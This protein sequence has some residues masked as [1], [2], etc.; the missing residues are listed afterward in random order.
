MTQKFDRMLKDKSYKYAPVVIEAGRIVN[1][2]Q[3]IWIDEGDDNSLRG[4]K[5]THAFYNIG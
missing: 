4:T 5:T 3:V 1:D 2:K